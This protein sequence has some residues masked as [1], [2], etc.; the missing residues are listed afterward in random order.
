MK[1]YDQ[2]EIKNPEGRV[3]IGRIKEIEKKNK[4]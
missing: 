2:W 3:K 4:K 1:R